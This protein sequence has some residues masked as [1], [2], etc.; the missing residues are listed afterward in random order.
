MTELVEK[1]NDDYLSLCRRLSRLPPDITNYY[2]LPTADQVRP[3]IADIEASL[4]PC[5][6]Q[7][8]K[9]AIKMLV[10]AYPKRELNDPEI[11]VKSLVG[12]LQDFP[13]DIVK[14]T[15]TDVRRHSRFLPTCADCYQTAYAYK[16]ERITM[17]HKAKAVLTE[18][19]RQVRVAPKSRQKKIAHGDHAEGA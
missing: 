3:L 14:Q 1:K 7:A 5:G 2:G 9:A 17:L 16:H 18:L 15:V 19:E 8:A 4:K 12:D 10:G 11:Y 13:L 6:E